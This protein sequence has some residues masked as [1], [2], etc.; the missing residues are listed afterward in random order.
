MKFPPCRPQYP[1]QNLLSS[2]ASPHLTTYGDRIGVQIYPGGCP[3]TD[4]HP[5]SVGCQQVVQDTD[6]RRDGADMAV[7]GTSGPP[8]PP[9]PPRPA[10]GPQPCVGP[11]SPP[12]SAQS[13]K[14]PSVRPSKAAL[15]QNPSSPRALATALGSPRSDKTAPKSNRLAMLAVRYMLQ[16]RW[17]CEECQILSI[18]FPVPLPVFSAS[19]PKQPAPYRPSHPL[20]ATTPLPPLPPSRFLSS[21]HPGIS[22]LSLMPPFPTSIPPP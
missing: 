17:H 20:L 11:P 6:G 2:A 4:V 21:G 13:Y 5:V 7:L 22:V 10:T 19:S 1:T 3:G 14:C 15:E 9:P 18:S 16:F 12:S 8:P